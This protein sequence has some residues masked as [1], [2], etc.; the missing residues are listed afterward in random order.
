MKLEN[1]KE[2]E[3]YWFYCEREEV[4]GEAPRAMLGQVS[5][6]GGG[7]RSVVLHKVLHLNGD[8]SGLEA[9]H[10]VAIEPGDV[11]RRADAED[12]LVRLPLVM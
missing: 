8:P 2:G 12:A 4:V 7:R 10:A 6:F 3:W 1:I 5:S 9:H 11:I